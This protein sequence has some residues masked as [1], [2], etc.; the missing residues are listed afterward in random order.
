M[1]DSRH[2]KLQVFEGDPI[3]RF[4]HKRALGSLLTYLP[5]VLLALCV[6]VSLNHER[7]SMSNW[8]S[9]LCHDFAT[10][11]RNNK[12]N[13]GHLRVA[14]A[15]PLTRDLES[16]ITVAIVGVTPSLIYRQWKALETGFVTMA[17]QGVIASETGA[18]PADFAKANEW[19]KRAGRCGSLW[20]AIAALAVL[21]LIAGETKG[22]FR[23]LAPRGSLRTQA[24]WSQHAYGSWW[25][26]IVS[27]R[28]GFVLYA[29]IGFV[30]MYYIT[31]MNVIGGRVVFLLRRTRD[32]LIYTADGS[33][34]DGY[35]GWGPARSI[36]LPTYWALYLHSVAIFMMLI[37]LDWRPWLILPA[38]L[39]W[40]VVL[41][42]YLVVPLRLAYRSI[43]AYK[44]D[45]QSR[46]VEELDKLEART[47]TPSV[48][49]S[50]EVWAQ[51]LA[52]VRDMRT[53][54]FSRPRD[55]AVI[56]FT[57]VPGVVTF[58]IELKRFW[59]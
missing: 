37:V 25:A 21:V 29:L 8:T 19:F 48:L 47:A 12:W 5:I 58:V 28:W 40:A 41:V 36:F 26:G 51:R 35:Y 3:L 27:N 17:R 13:C 59:G 43:S 9:V 33:N 57:V 50:R 2:L 39:E 38:L 55:V 23:S 24:I 32:E 14:P 30:G 20:A 49:S 42:P 4:L 6:L 15:F 16:I 10:L 54:P 7:F 44:V 22:I 18:T 1:S 31:L 45:E 52:R 34:R 53:M 56:F 11:V 46:I